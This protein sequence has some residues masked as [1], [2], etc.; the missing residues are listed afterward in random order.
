MARRFFFSEPKAGRPFE[1]RRNEAGSRLYFS[2]VDVKL[3]KNGMFPLDW[4]SKTMVWSVRREIQDNASKEW[5]R[6]PTDPFTNLGLHNPS[7][8]FP[9]LHKVRR[10]SD[11][12]ARKL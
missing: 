1:K 4:P 12:E 6:T 5:L 9:D 7:H 2:T 11:A 8:Y 10:S 3:Y